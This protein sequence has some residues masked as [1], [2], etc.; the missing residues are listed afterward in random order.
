MENKEKFKDKI[1]DIACNGG[2]IAVDKVTYEPV[3]CNI[4][5]C[6]SCLF[7]GCGTCSK[8]LIEW[9]NQE[10]KDPIVILE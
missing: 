6:S 7:Y 1:V 10:Y 4:I 8:A 2:S 5:D 3:D 9:A